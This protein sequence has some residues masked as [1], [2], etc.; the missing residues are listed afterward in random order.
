MTLYKNIFSMH[1]QI[2]LILNQ[3]KNNP[4]KGF[5][6]VHTN[7]LCKPLSEGITCIS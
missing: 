1:T 5:T 3:C 2:I 6:G 7:K 4:Q